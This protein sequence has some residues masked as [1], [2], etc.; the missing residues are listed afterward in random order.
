MFIAYD[1]EQ[2]SVFWVPKALLLLSLNIRLG[3]GDTVYLFVL[4]TRY[5]Q[6]LEEVDKELGCV[7][8]KWNT[9]DEEDLTPAVLKELNNETNVEAG[10]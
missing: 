8:L 9:T 4:C 10:D 3:R 6:I 2:G 1:E 5:T 7:C